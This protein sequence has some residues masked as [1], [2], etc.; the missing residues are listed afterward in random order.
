MEKVYVGYVQGVHGLRGDLKVKCS[1]EK[2]EK[3][4]IK[5]AN[6]FLEDEEHTITNF[7]FYKG[8]YLVTID[9]IKDI[10]AVEKYKGYDVFIDRENLN[11]DGEY[12]LD[13]LYG[14]RIK[15][16]TDDFGVVKE[17]LDNGTYKILVVDY[18]KRYM[19]PLVD[20]YV[21]KVNLETGEIEVENVR[22]LII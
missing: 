14:M 3:V 8:F 12:I 20:E 21:K 2:P 5:D 1:F 13:D 10:N 22:S 7:K 16:N 6:I 18:D 4:F 11:L 19:I 15:E 9:N 17:I